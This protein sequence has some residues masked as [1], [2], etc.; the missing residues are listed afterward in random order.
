MRGDIS[1]DARRRLTSV[2]PRLGTDVELKRRVASGPVAET[3][4]THAADVNADLIVVGRSRRFLHLG[5]T[6]VR[7][8][9][10]TN[11]A[12]LVIPPAATAQTVQPEAS[13]HT[14]AA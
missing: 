2:M 6:A 4:G 3:I 12:L 10:S 5:S 14:R 11:R 1:G 8:L 9:R 13:V 7:L